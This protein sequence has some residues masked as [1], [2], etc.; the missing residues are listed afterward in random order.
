MIE[1]SNQAGRL[2]L[3]GN[4]LWSLVGTASFAGCNWLQIVAISKYF[5]SPAVVGRYALGLAVSLPMLALA[6]L[7]LR[8]VLSTDAKETRPFS[9]YLRLRVLTC[10]I[11]L[12]LTPLVAYLAYPDAL[13]VIVLVVAVRVGE[14]IADVFHGLYQRRE[15][16]DRYA[17]SQGIRAVLSLGAF[18]SGLW[19]WG[20]LVPAL[21]AQL[22]VSLL[23]V[24]SLDPG[25]ARKLRTAN[26]E[27]ASGGLMSLLTLAAPLGAVVFLGAL[28]LNL[29]RYFIEEVLGARSLGLFAAIASLVSVATI[30]ASALGHAVVPRLAN[31]FAEGDFAAF[32]RLVWRLLGIAASL[33]VAGLIVTWLVGEPLL[34]LVYGPEYASGVGLLFVLF[35]FA[36]LNY[37]TGYLGAAVTAM[38]EFRIQL[39][40]QFARLLVVGLLCWALIPSYGLM[41]A[42][43]A[44][45]VSQA[46]AVFLYYQVARWFLGRAHQSFLRTG[47]EVS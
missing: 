31:Y 33:G 4:F 15:R 18:M 17:I 41:G 27:P 13:V 7:E 40:T 44:L 21:L 3:R 10:G 30:V 6:N 12:L 14:A 46:F 16:M 43:W 42:A 19:I 32:S 28:Q 24:A 2:T 20:E 5:E 38:R 1:L 8:A 47:T 9:D 22:A 34:R 36:G 23:V 25:M 11:V 35:I 45:V 37:M 29:P 39:V 26:Q